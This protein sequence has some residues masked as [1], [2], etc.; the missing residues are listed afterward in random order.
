MVKDTNEGEKRLISLL[1]LENS[2]DLSHLLLEEGEPVFILRKKE[3]EEA[4]ILSKEKGKDRGNKRG[5]GTSS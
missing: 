5:T 2:Q 4:C 1:T 3:E